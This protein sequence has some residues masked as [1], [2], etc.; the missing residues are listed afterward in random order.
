MKVNEM[1]KREVIKVRRSTSLRNL[2]NTFKNFHT[3]PLIPVVDENDFLIGVV[4]LANLLDILKPP[5]VKFLKNIPFA[6]V[7]EDVFDLELAPAMGELILVDDIM[8]INF[9]SLE[10]DTSLEEAYKTM[11]LHNCDQL[12]VVDK[13]NKLLGIIGI[14]DIVWRVFK[15]KGVV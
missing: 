5:Q 6:E 11:R 12:P 7:D 10:E 15:E 14:F 9:I 3:L 2:L 8:E 1:M 13:Q 4:Y